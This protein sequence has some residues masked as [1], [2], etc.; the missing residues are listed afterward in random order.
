MLLYCDFK[1]IIE[2]RFYRFW[3]LVLQ[4]CSRYHEWCRSFSKQL[5]NITIE[6]EM[7]VEF[8]STGLKLFVCLWT[9]VEKLI[10]KFPGVVDIV[11]K[12][13][14]C[15]N[16]KILD[17]MRGKNYFCKISS[18]FSQIFIQTCIFIQLTILQVV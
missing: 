6:N 4:L 15:S 7:E 17:Y 2:I 8:D 13:L 3:K 10:E 16:S 14:P 5:S 1:V 12:K 18:I 11:A 9:D